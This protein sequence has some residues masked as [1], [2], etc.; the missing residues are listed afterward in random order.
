MMIS[1]ENLFEFMRDFFWPFD[2]NFSV[3]PLPSSHS[4]VFQPKKA[5]SPSPK[6]KSAP[7][8]RS[9]SPATKKKSGTK[10]SK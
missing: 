3:Q 1:L 9:P 8:S 2:D 5:H 4:N 7:N 6:K 10:K